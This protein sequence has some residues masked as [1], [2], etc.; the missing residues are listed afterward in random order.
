MSCLDRGR[1]YLPTLCSAL[2]LNFVNDLT[3]TSELW[4]YFDHGPTP[5]TGTCCLK[6]AFRVVNLDV[7]TECFHLTLPERVFNAAECC[8]K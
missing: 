7:W 2:P 5:K 6:S 4:S 8:L 3:S 1:S